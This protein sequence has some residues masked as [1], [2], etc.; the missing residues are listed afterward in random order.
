MH[1]NVL[2]YQYYPQVISKDGIA[3][4]ILPEY[5]MTFHPPLL[6][7]NILPHPVSVILADSQ[8]EQ[9]M[10]NIGVGGFVEVYQFD[11]SKKIRMSVNTQ[12]SCFFSQAVLLG[13]KSLT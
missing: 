7:H 11:M 1:L 2:P 3:S 8:A 13:N 4:N 5:V 6:V 10:F 12:A 9:S